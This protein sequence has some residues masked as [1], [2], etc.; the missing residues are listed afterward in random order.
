MA[1]HNSYL[2]L[3][4]D[5][6]SQQFWQD[7]AEESFLHMAVTEMVW[8]YSACVWAAPEHPVWFYSCAWHLGRD[9]REA[10]LNWG[11]LLSVQSLGFEMYPLPSG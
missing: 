11:P 5:F 4:Q 10:G 8:W 7:S 2:I 3:F 6:V 9:C 1:Y